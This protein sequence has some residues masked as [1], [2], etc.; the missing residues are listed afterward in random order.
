MNRFETLGIDLD[1]TTYDFYTLFR[2]W[3]A[4]LNNI[5]PVSLGN[6][7][8]KWSFFED[9]GCSLSTFKEMLREGVL[10]RRLYWEGDAYPDAVETI[11]SLSE[12]HRIVI[13]TSRNFLGLEREMEAATTHWLKT[14]DIPFDQLILTDVKT[15]LG[16]DLMLDDAPHIIQAARDAGEAAV[17]FDAPH[18]RH[19][20][21]DRV[22]NWKEFEEYVRA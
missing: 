11:Q 21:N 4:E 7:P 13:V 22:L 6:E 3:Y 17:V 1:G 14:N 10:N 16:L 19:V 5:D 15:N 12:D 18:N 20:V 2:D 9:G 8:E